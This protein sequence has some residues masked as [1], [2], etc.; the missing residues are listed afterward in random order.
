[1]TLR[2]AFGALG[3]DSTLQSIRDRLGMLA[4]LT[5]DSSARLRV[6]SDSI[7][8]SGTPA[9]SISGTPA[10]NQTQIGGLAANDHIPALMAMRADNL[11]RNITVT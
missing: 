4:L 7:I 6:V 3:L 9:V 8:I 5:F 10:V 1:M 11:R 2:N